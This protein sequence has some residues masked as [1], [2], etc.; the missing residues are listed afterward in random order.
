[1]SGEDRAALVTDH[2]L[3]LAGADRGEALALAAVALYRHADGLLEEARR[4]VHAAMRALDRVG[5]CPWITNGTAKA[6][7]DAGRRL[8]EFDEKTLAHLRPALR[9]SFSGG[10]E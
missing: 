4:D 5:A 2:V 8:E 9:E 7:A 1:M 10:E 3:E 6:I